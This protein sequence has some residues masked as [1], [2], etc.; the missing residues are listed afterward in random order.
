MNII[1]HRAKK[2]RL[3]SSEMIVSSL[4]IRRPSLIKIIVY[5]YIDSRII[6]TRERNTRDSIERDQ[7]IQREQLANRNDDD[8]W[9]D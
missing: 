7:R 9:I 8:K 2:L 6:E 4:P 5:L 1:K 3:F